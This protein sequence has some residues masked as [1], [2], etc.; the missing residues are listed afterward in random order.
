[1]YRNRNHRRCK[2][3]YYSLLKLQNEFNWVET[4]LNGWFVACKF[5]LETLVLLTKVLDSGQ[6]TSVIVGADQE[7]LLLDPGFLIGDIPEG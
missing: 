5:R 3:G 2:L 4:N 1:M 7:F 6:I